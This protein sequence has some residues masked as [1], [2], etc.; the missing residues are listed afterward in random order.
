VA[1][2]APLATRITVTGHPNQYYQAGKSWAL[3]QPVVGN[4][5]YQLTFWGRAVAGLPGLIHFKLQHKGDPTTGFAEKAFALSADWAEYAWTLTAPQ[6]LTPQSGEFALFVGA[7]D[8]TIELSAIRLVKALPPLRIAGDLLPGMVTVVGHGGSLSHTVNQTGP[9]GV[10]AARLE[11]SVL[12][13]NH[14]ETQL[15]AVWSE[16]VASGDIFEGSVWARRLPA[17]AGPAMVNLQFQRRDWS[18]TSD[19][20][21]T[22]AMFS[23]LVDHMDWRQVRFTFSA[24]ET[25]A[26]RPDN[27]A[28]VAVNLGFGPQL[29]ELAGL[30]LTNRRRNVTLASL[31]TDFATYPGREADAPWRQAA[32]ADI[33]KHRKADYT[34]RVRYASGG[35]MPGSRVMSLALEVP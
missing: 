13:D 3:P 7:K 18:F 31:P 11:T 23:R 17:S 34:V 2:T 29:V 24:L 32:A 22:T 19:T 25:M 14:W 8:Q 33:E 1:I 26:T 35:P 28:Q 9:G 30:V 4:E 12:P 6:D 10:E 21:R 20:W 27:R 16:P 5:R 15:T